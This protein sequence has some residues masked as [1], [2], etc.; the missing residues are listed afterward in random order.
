M[1]VIIQTT[2]QVKDLIYLSSDMQDIT[3]DFINLYQNFDINKDGI[4]IMTLSDYNFYKKVISDFEKMDKIINDL[5]VVYP[6]K[7]DLINEVIDNNSHLDLQD[8]PTFT[9]NELENTVL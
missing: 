4:T 2:Q 6:Q 9:I 5:K 3:Q 8:I 7:I 1:K